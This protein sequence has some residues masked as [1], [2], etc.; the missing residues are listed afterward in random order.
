MKLLRVNFTGSNFNF[1]VFTDGADRVGRPKNLG[2]AFRFYQLDNRL[3]LSVESPKILAR[4]LGRSGA[5]RFDHLSDLGFERCPVTVGD[6]KKFTLFS[7]VG[8]ARDE[9]LASGPG[10]EDLVA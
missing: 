8:P 1:S 6:A 4:G 2:L 10:L 5:W 7:A 9:A 3:V